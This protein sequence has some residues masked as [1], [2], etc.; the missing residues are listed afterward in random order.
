MMWHLNQALRRLSLAYVRG[1]K[2][3]LFSFSTALDAEVNSTEKPV[4]RC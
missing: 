4:T 1:T 2:W 3:D